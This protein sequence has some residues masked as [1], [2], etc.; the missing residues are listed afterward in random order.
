MQR[1]NQN[2]QRHRS[3]DS[4]Q[5]E[6]SQPDTALEEDQFE[7]AVEERT[8]LQNWMVR[9]PSVPENPEEYQYIPPSPSPSPSEAGPSAPRR[10][11]RERRAPERYGPQSNSEDEQGYGTGFRLRYCSV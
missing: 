3:K 9:L 1:L 7:D 2:V 4:N 10:S 6:Q 11:T 8:H 5:K